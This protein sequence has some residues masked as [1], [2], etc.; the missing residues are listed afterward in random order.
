MRL[1]C[2][3]DLWL[4]VAF[5]ARDTCRSVRHELLMLLMQMFQE[6]HNRDITFIIFALS[7]CLI[8]T[9][10]DTDGLRTVPN[11]MFLDILLF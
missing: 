6:N 2:S 9:Q 4:G 8:A 3:S 10:T 11:A 1:I 7:C 5:R